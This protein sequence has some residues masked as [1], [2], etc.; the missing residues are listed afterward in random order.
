MVRCLIYGAIESLRFLLRCSTCINRAQLSGKLFKHLQFGVVFIANVAR[1]PKLINCW[2]IIQVKTIRIH[3]YGYLWRRIEMF[4]CFITAQKIQDENHQRDCIQFLWLW[5]WVIWIQ[6]LIHDT[7]H[8]YNFFWVQYRTP[9]HN[10]LP[11]KRCD[12]EIFAMN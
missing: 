7:K 12:G 6:A 2:V 4:T 9:G 8:A 3:W 1:T 10:R 11:F 5:F